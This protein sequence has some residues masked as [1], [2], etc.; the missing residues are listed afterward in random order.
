MLI[1]IPPLR[2]RSFHRAYFDTDVFFHL[3]SRALVKANKDDRRGYAFP[4]Q[5]SVAK[6]LNFFGRAF[7]KFGSQGMFCGARK[8][9]ERVPEVVE[10]FLQRRRRRPGDGWSR[11]ASEPSVG[12]AWAL[13]IVE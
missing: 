11:L 13:L 9:E 4:S 12:A 10:V 8:R 3:L 6:W 1:T 2:A 5:P 7:G